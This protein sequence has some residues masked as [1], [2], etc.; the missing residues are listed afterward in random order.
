MSSFLD[1]I[2]VGIQR[3]VLPMIVPD[4]TTDNCR[5]RYKHC[6]DKSLYS[7]CFV[8]QEEPEHLPGNC[9]LHHSAIPWIARL[10]LP[11]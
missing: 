6:R 1:M 5:S 4:P 11:A 7:I 2:K 3:P 8:P 10:L 9:L